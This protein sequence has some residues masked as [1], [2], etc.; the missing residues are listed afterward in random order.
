MFGLVL[1]GGGSKGAYQIG[2]CK[3][4]KEMGMEFSGIAGTSVGALNG[5]MV[6]QDDLDKAFEMWYNIDPSKVFN[7][8]A[9]ELA[10]LNNIEL[11]GDS[12]NA[13]FRRI[14]K[15]I[16]EKGLDVGPLIEMVRS[17]VDESKIR[18]SPKD[19]GIVTV[20]LT[21]RKPVEIYKEEI[22]QGKLV[23]YLIAS[24]SFPGFKLKAIDGKLFIDGALYNALPINLVKDKG[25]K[26][27][28]V[29]RTYGIGRIQKVDTAG[30]NI[31]YIAP[32]ESLGTVLD[33]GNGRARKS[34][35]MGYYDALKVFKGLKGK[36]YYI[37]P[38]ND[39]GTIID[40]LS[41]L[42]E[43][44]IGKIGRIFGV[45]KCSGKRVLFEYIV[46]KV[47]DLLGVS[48]GASYEDVLIC[49]LESIAEANGIQ[50]F[51]V[52]D[53][54]EL[55]SCIAN[56]GLSAKA[57]FIEEI[58]GFLR[59]KELVSKFVKDKIIEYVAGELFYPAK[60]DVS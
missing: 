24:A 2:A 37:R 55:L 26:D 42:D 58:P 8:S 36:K 17:V 12:I 33:F 47:A 11:R 5:A 25:Y 1:E 28:V 15:V 57:G 59:G 6:V 43:E 52:Y 53:V 16:L 14:K 30:L 22:P 4:L 60:E 32:T 10:E 46:P 50:R 31:T 39:E 56:C 45:E 54:T 3:A 20:D 18:K 23:D 9:E 51:K 29:I 38:L 40:F 41:R 35:N 34:L 19:F 27:I 21:A 13:V 7:F 48:A 49:L 44:K